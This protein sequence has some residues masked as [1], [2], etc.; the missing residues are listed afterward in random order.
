MDNLLKTRITNL[1]AGEIR[2]KRAQS[3]KLTEQENLSLR[4]MMCWSTK[5]HK[6]SK[7]QE[8]WQ[9]MCDKLNTFKAHFKYVEPNN[10]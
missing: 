1:T 7:I 5:D 2:K 4:A 3:V 6:G 10:S 9:K 8:G